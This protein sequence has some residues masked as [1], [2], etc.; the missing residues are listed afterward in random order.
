M[1]Q[2]TQEYFEANQQLQDRPALRWYARVCRRLVGRPG[3]DIFEFGCGVGW[4]LH[5]LA[6]RHGQKISGYDLSDFC[7]DQ[8]RTRCPTVSVYDDLNAVPN[9]AFDLVVSLH[10][11]EHVPD[12]Q[13][14]FQRLASLLRPCGKL[15][16]VVPATTGLGHRIKRKGW[17]AYR[18]E[19][20]ISLLSEI[21]WTE[22]VRAA[23]LR[24]LRQAGDGLWDPPYVSWL[25]RV[26]QAPL[27]GAPAALQVY[28][29]RGRLFVPARWSECLIVV[30]QR[31]GPAEP[32]L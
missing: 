8:T 4:L 9:S 11:L 5:H 32:T 22:H 1:S 28:L 6:T 27:F 29:G 19:T 20:H 31:P 10:V 25:P 17:F 15:L 21:E 14:T 26:I 2:Y 18:D 3:G 16:F 23:G 7:R 24:I 30:A 12:P 13:P